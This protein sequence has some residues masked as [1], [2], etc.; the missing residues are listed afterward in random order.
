MLIIALLSEFRVLW[1][2]WYIAP[3]THIPLN[4]YPIKWKLSKHHLFFYF[5]EFRSTCINT[6]NLPEF[7]PTTLIGLYLICVVVWKGTHSPWFLPCGSMPPAVDFHLLLCPREV[8]AS[9][10]LSATERSFY[11]GPPHL[12]QWFALISHITCPR[13][14]LLSSFPVFHLSVS[15]PLPQ[16]LSSQWFSCTLCL[17]SAVVPLCAHSLEERHKSV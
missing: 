12:P 16:W 10:I 7:H 9:I 6:L 4:S 14:V 5:G 2:Y 3:L 17:F 13:T 11:V 8:T 1:C 15:F